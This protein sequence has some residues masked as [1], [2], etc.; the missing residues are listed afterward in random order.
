MLQK[1]NQVYTDR[2]KRGGEGTKKEG[3]REDNKISPDKREFTHWLGRMARV[4]PSRIT[5]GTVGRN[6]ER[7]TRC[8]VEE[9]E[10]LWGV[11]IYISPQAI[12]Q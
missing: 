8:L 4:Q 11:V 10:G 2:D 1:K 9:W 5:V 7:L 6:D 12:I 3:M